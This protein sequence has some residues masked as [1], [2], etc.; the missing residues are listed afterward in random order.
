VPYTEQ[1]SIGTERTFD[2]D[3]TGMVKLRY[4]LIGMVEK[5]AFELRRKGKLTGCVT[6]KIRYANFDTHTLQKHIPYTAFD[7]VLLETA[8]E[9]SRHLYQRRMR[10]RLIGVRFSHLAGGSQQLDIFDEKPEL[11]NFYQAM[12][13]IRRRYGKQAVQRAADNV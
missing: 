8:L 13:H 10:I 3:T 1:K 7:H 6:V 2:R 12:D 5:I 11:V 4:I 9:L